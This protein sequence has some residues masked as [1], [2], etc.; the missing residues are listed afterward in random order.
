MPRNP[1]ASIPKG[2]VDGLKKVRGVWYYK[3]K[4]DGRGHHGSTG[5]VDKDQ[6]RLYVIRLREDIR[7]RERRKDSLMTIDAISR[8]YVESRSDRSA[9]FLA[10]Y[11]YSQRLMIE[12]FGDIRIDE[13]THSDINRLKDAYMTQRKSNGALHNRGG[14]RTVL[15]DVRSTLNFAVKAGIVRELPFK[16]EV[17]KAQKAPVQALV[18]S[19]VQDFLEAAKKHARDPQ[20]FLAI[21]VM[22]YLGLRIGEITTMKWEWFRDDFQAYAPGLTKGLEGEFLPVPLALATQL[23]EWREAS[24]RHWQLANRPMPATV[25]WSK[26]GD[27]RSSSFTD[28]TIKFAA[29]AIGREGR[30][31]PHR[32]RATCATILAEAGVSAHHIQRIL[33][34]KK[35]DTTL[36][37]VRVTERELRNSQTR[38]IEALGAGE[39]PIPLTPSDE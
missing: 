12:H 29:K 35:I 20:V 14:L 30:W 9:G 39:I 31:S 11:A 22:V 18:M 6:A 10:R 3:F 25:F 15:I 28:P 36:H 37:Y 24:R 34:H 1:N 26:R 23:F 8:F 32:L 33:R 7:R 27:E 16:I 4:L 17:P 38:M 2:Y 5:L 19:E 21:Q 13:L